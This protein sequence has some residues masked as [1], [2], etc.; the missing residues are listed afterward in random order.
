ME[1]LWLK[2]AKR[3]QALSSTGLS[4]C[5]DEYDKE[6]YEEILQISLEMIALIGDVPIQRIEELLTMHSKGYVTPKIDV[7]GAVFQDEKILLVREKSDGLWT[8]PGGFA[9][10]GL[11]AAENI[12][13][14]IREEASISVTARK[15][16]A[17]RHKSM[18]K[19]KDDAR[20][21][22]KLFFLCDKS[23]SAQVRAGL[24][25][26]EARYFSQTEIPKLSTARVVIDDLNLAWQHVKEPSMVASFD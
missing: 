3:L 10:V 23:D 22:Y 16:Y 15:L 17:V 9:D 21:F 25:T 1:D 2:F 18:G 12:E 20:D 11:S 4:Y 7:R 13:K 5:K 26:T 24:E 19:Y 6:R 14:E 8:L